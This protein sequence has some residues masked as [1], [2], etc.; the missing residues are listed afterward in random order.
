[1]GTQSLERHILVDIAFEACDDDSAKVVRQHLFAKQK[2]L[3]V[4]IN[5]EMS[6]HTV[7]GYLFIL[8]KITMVRF[9]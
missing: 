4:E 5:D 2:S 9:E 1:M 7:S 3:H 6:A 8:E